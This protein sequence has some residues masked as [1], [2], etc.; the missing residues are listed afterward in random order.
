[1]SAEA[2]GYAAARQYAIVAALEDLHGPTSGAVV[3]PKRLDW[4]PARRFDLA[5]RADV[6]VM[7]ETVLRESR[8]QGDLGDFLDAGLLVSVWQSLVLPVQVRAVWESRF[9]QLRQ[10]RAA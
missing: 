1:M 8:G 4:A 5:D 3:L 2:V 9:A 6:A 7:Y 10:G